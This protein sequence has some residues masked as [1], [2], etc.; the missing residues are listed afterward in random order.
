M[1]F[2]K[3]GVDRRINTVGGKLMVTFVLVALIIA[4][5]LGGISTIISSQSIFN[6]GSAS[7]CEIAAKTS[8]AI[9]NK[10]EGN[11]KM[12][13]V[14]SQTASVKDSNIDLNKKIDYITDIVK[15]DNL[16]E[17][18]IADLNGNVQ[19]KNSTAKVDHRE[20]FQS[21]IKD[22]KITVSSPM[23]SSN[24]AH[25]GAVV[26]TFCAPIHDSDN[27]ITSTIIADI[28][29]DELTSIVND[30]KI[31]N[32]GKAFMID[33]TGN[34]IAHANTD[35]IGKLNIFTEG[36]KNKDFK[37]MSSTIKTMMSSE[38]TVSRVKVN[39]KKMVITN[40]PV[41]G[42][43]WTLIVQI[44]EDEL[45]ESI[46]LGKKL[47]L[48][49][50]VITI[51]ISVSIVY[52]QIKGISKSIGYTTK[53]L[54]YISKGDFT[55]P[56]NI[57]LINR[58]DELGI[59]GQAMNN[60]QIKLRDTLS[61]LQENVQG[62][63]V[64]SQNLA[65]VSEE[66]SSAADTVS[67]S[68]QD[69]AKGA[70]GQSSDM[71]NVVYNMEMFN[72]VIEK[73]LNAIDEI[74]SNNDVIYNLSDKSNK[75][76]NQ[77]IN[78]VDNVTTAFEGL[79]KQVEFVGENISKVNNIITVVNTISER[80]NLLALNAAIEAARVGDAGKGFAV[81]AEEIRK[82]AEQSRISVSDIT[83]L[84]NNIFDEAGIMV[85]NTNAVKEEV[86]NQKGVILNAVNN[87]SDI[88][89]AV[90]N[91]KPKIEKS[92]EL[93]AKII[94]NKE[95]VINKIQ[96][97]SSVSQEVSAAAEEISAIS[98]EAMSSSQEVAKAAEDL[99]EMTRTIK[100]N[101]LEFKI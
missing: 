56:I 55:N 57:K 98:E 54:N 31:G 101:L 18:G 34:I 62:L 73:V 5:S 100:N 99:T 33:G 87:F 47:M 69:V 80:T 19:F 2:G 24:K 44:D 39:D 27:K 74:K 76:M 37:D 71:V 75:D 72:E 97:A 70:E 17:I 41:K 81:V 78:S 32:T 50:A 21:T 58:S 6:L 16:L 7:L 92:K 68:V 43:D 63:D 65:S 61:N 42:T 23:V 28:K 4:G 51:L 1:T 13:E 20:Y 66:L 49:L 96:S 60:M 25:N 46:N 12:Y 30:V 3:K 8:D 93:G 14:I 52:I 26:L 84:L 86:F 85:K 83:N 11:K 77:V 67:E 90:E 53:S 79:V 9:L 45:F 82:L 38:K 89:G 36:E 35:Y 40:T 48:V 64:S 94:D 29:V 88:T 59:M 15:A 95:V 22:N 10:L 91:M